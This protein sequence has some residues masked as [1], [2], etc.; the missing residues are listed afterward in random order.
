MAIDTPE[1]TEPEIHVLDHGEDVFHP[2]PVP[3]RRTSAARAM[4]V[5]IVALVVAALLDADGLRQTAERQ[6]P[7]T[8][9]D[10]AIWATK[11]VVQPVSH[12]TGL[13][14]PRRWINEALGVANE[15]HITDTRNVRLAPATRPPVV[16][17]AAP[18]PPPTTLALRTPTAAD[19]LKVLVTG[20]SLSENLFPPLV[21]VANGKP[22]TV[23]EDSQIGTGLARPDVIDWPTRLGNDMRANG[24][25]TVVVMF[26]GNDAQ[27]LRTATGWVHIGD[28]DA[29]KLEYERRV[30][31]VM[32]TLIMGNPKVTIVWVGMPA[33][34]GGSK[35]LPRLAPQINDMVRR[36]AAARP[37]NAYFVDAGQVLDGP[38]GTF[39]T[40]AT[41]PD[42]TTVK[43]RE[44]DGVH[45]TI[46]GAKRIVEQQ[47]LP[48]V[49]L[50]YHLIP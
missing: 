24:Y 5:V 31:L 17:D 4:V 26:G 44:G 47:V 10:F 41:N 8:T 12:A 28:P 27:D 3:R 22:I 25:D 21:S 37:A 2:E 1:T 49:A 18:P 46:P 40:Y 19:P 14:R 32:D 34:T 45:F 50:R 7:G 29:W 15:P 30:A 11:H 20:D 6:K 33:M 48:I 9:R 23:K 38:G 35:Y 42:G 39:R 13:N 16:P 36:E 43:V